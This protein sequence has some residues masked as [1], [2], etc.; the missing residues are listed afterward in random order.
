[1]TMDDPFQGKSIPEVENDAKSRLTE[2]AYKDA[3][4]LGDQINERPHTQQHITNVM[5]E[6]SKEL[7]NRAGNMQDYNAFLLTVASETSHRPTS[8]YHFELKDWNAN[9]GT[10]NCVELLTQD[11]AVFKVVQPGD[12]LGRIAQYYQ[13][14]YEDR[15]QYMDRLAKVNKIQDPNKI[16]VGE[17]INL[18]HGD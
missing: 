7:E 16:I 10:W 17:S 11:N 4:S 2:D 14:D 15:S 12:T 9:S 8:D 5:S 3:K 6:I 18:L 1:M 13:P